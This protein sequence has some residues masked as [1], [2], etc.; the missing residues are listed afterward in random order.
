MITGPSVQV[1]SEL[2]ELNKDLYELRRS[3]PIINALLYTAQHN[4]MAERPTMLA[5]ITMLERERARLHDLV[6]RNEFLRP[7]VLQVNS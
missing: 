5:I 7:Y 6:V 1:T 2:D 3:S 4:E